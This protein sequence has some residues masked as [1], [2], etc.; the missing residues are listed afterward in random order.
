[1]HFNM[2]FRKPIPFAKLALYNKKWKIEV[3][4][5]FT[6]KRVFNYEWLKENIPLFC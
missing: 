3:R 5:R 2:F 6:K 4:N 1:M